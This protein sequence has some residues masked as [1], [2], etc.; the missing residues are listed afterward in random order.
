MADVVLYNADDIIDKTLYALARVPI[1]DL[2]FEKVN[3]QLQQ[4]VGYVE[5]GNMVGVVYSYVLPDPTRDRQHLYWEFYRTDGTVY[6]TP[7]YAGLYDDAFLKGQG[8][9]TEEEKAAAA[10][11]ANLPWYEQ[12]LTKYG[13]PLVI[14][15]LITSVVTAGVKGYLSRPKSSQ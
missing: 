14:G 7:Q 12:L 2:P 5:P 11:D 15:L 9:Q 13:K 6:W 3:G 4:P 8:V 10:A 1:F